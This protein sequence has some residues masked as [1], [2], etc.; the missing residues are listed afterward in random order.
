MGKEP[1]ISIIIPTLNAGISIDAAIKSVLQQNYSAIELIVIDGGSNEKELQRLIKYQNSINYFVSEKDTGVYSAINKGIRAS[2]NDWIY[3]LGSD[4]RFATSD[5]LTR[6]LS[7]T[8]PNTRLVYG[9]VQN[10]NQK[11]LLIPSNFSN[12][13]RYGL[14]WRNT[15]HQQGVFYHK[16]LFETELFNEERKV[17]ADY[18]MHLKLFQSK[19]QAIY[20]P[21]VVAISNATGLSKQFNWDL[22]HEELVIKRDCLPSPFYWINIPWIVAK[23]VIKKATSIL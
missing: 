2:K 16:S 15:M 5:V 18:E 13:F 14:L 11:H 9:D 10:A 7:V 8:Q 23:F 12:R 3:I 4:D 20:N 22:Y 1:S 17:L 21:I 6:M 19:T